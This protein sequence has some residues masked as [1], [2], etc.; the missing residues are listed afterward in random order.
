MVA[1]AG[2]GWTMA[3][4]RPLGM[5]AHAK[6]G[7]FAVLNANQAVSLGNH[8]LVVGGKNERRLEC[9]RLIRF[10]RSRISSPVL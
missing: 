10:I 9:L 5:R 6:Q 7:D 3:S 8:P 1:G 4:D 2:F